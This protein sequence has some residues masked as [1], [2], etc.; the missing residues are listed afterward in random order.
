[1]TEQVQPWADSL[2][3][4]WLLAPGPGLLREVLLLA[5]QTHPRS[6]QTRPGISSVGRCRR[7]A[8][9]GLAGTPPDP[10]WRPNPSPAAWVGTWAHQGILP[11]LKRLLH[12]ARIEMPVAWTPA[13]AAVPLPGRAD[14]YRRRSRLVL[15]VKVVSPWQLDAARR[16]GYRTRDLTQ[17]HGYAAALRQMGHPVDYVAVLY[18]TSATSMAEQDDEGHLHVQPVDEQVISEAVAWW[19]DVQALS[20]GVDASPEAMWGGRD[21]PGPGL[22]LACD[23]CRWLRRCWGADAEPGSPAAVAISPFD[24]EA[25]SEAVADY[26][27]GAELERRGAALK[28]Q[29]RAELA[30]APPGTYGAWTLS[31]GKPGQR[32]DGAAAAKLLRSMGLPV[33]MTSTAPSI[34]VRPAPHASEPGAG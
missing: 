2:A 27:E 10:A 3:R 21:E 28:K 26:A 18:V 7:Q 11:L 30:E 31:W 4:P 19:A 6:Q 23:S 1:M 34:S 20:E 32:V 29:A 17:V 13:P 33:P 22:S 24:T 25:I 12:P 5:E 9:Y 16:E 14:L 15:D 8:A